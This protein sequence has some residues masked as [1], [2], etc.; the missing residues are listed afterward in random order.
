MEERKEILR[1]IITGDIVHSTQVSPVDRKKL[2]RTLQL[3]VKDLKV[4]GTDLK[5]EVFRGDS[6]QI[7]VSAVEETLRVALIIRTGLMKDT[8]GT[9]KWDARLALGLGSVN[10]VS[11]HVISSDGEAFRN[12][13]REFDL[14]GK[15]RL[16][17]RSPWDD[18]NDEFKVSTAFTDALVQDWSISQATAIYYFLLFKDLNQKQLAEHMKLTPQGLNKRLMAARAQLIRFYL[19]RYEQLI[20]QKK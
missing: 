12:S 7:V 15:S 19:E 3:V 16:A 10:F 20:T 1:G 5:F 18:F 9:D 8:V 4:N 11:S 17:I 13:G 14:L 2:L 6:F